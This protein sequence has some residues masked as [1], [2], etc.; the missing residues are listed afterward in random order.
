MSKI[1]ENYLILPLLLTGCQFAL[2]SP[3]LA[4]ESVFDRVREA[5]QVDRLIAA[6]TIRL[7]EDN[8]REFPN[9]DYGPD[10][11]DMSFQRK[12]YVLD[13]E[14]QRGSVEYLAE[15]TSTFFH[16][17]RILSDEKSR[18]V[19]Y[20]PDIYMDEGER[21]FMSEFGHVIRAYDPLLALWLT[22]SAETATIEDDEVW[23]GMLH[24][25]V[26]INFPGSVPITILVDKDT[27]YIT[28]MTRIVGENTKVSY[29][30]DRHKVQDGIAIA[31]EANVYGGRNQVSYTFARKIVLNDGNDRTAFEMDAG[32]RPEPKRIDQSEMTIDKISNTIYHAGQGAA[33]SSFIR[34]DDG[35][36]A[37]GLAGG[38]SARLKAYRSATGD[39]SAL[40]YGVVTDHHEIE[41]AGAVEAA[42][43]GAT[44]LITTDATV[45]TQAATEQET[46]TKIEVIDKPRKFGS[47]ELIPVS[48]SHASKALVGYISNDRVLVQKGNWV[49]WFENEPVWADISDL[50]LYD[51]MKPYNLQ[52]EKLLSTDGRGTGDWAVFVDQVENYERISCHRNRPICQNWH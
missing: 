27:G 41:L 39:S 30:F 25:K 10:Y 38:F 42:R 31:T 48:T 43:L 22:K 45:R 21:P 51:A 17:R 14:S 35:L 33:Y 2:E 11:H 4:Q 9:H 23:M 26:T 15:I 29:T 40:R 5:Y 7:E 32:I 47:L 1:C 3:A 44:L 37:Y 8:R 52:I 24:D 6:K 16:T 46:N 34:T 28:K 18:H 19:I 13:I 12:H 50:T 20:G 49:K 36:V